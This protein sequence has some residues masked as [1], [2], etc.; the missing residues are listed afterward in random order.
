[1]NDPSKPDKVMECCRKVMDWKVG[2]CYLKKYCPE[3][4]PNFLNDMLAIFTKAKIYDKMA[5]IH[6]K[7][8]SPCTK[9]VSLYLKSQSYKKAKNALVGF[10]LTENQVAEIILELN[11]AQSIEVNSINTII[12]NLAYWKNRLEIVQRLKSN[13][14]N[15]LDDDIA[16]G[17]S[18][19][20]KDSVISGT[21]DSSKVSKFTGM[22]L[23]FKSKNKKPQNLISRKH[24]EGSLYEEE[25]LVESL[26]KSTVDGKQMKSWGHFLSLLINFGL[27]AQ[28]K[29]L[30]NSLEKYFK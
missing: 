26:N 5:A 29:E 10:S 8:K 9:I 27:V 6:K 14:L 22:S 20:S 25:W 13:P 18:Y 17:V 23:H 3:K 21:S 1:M 30:K 24:K 11:L 12:K 2:H 15:D 7:L 19:Q 28:F 16:D 4:I